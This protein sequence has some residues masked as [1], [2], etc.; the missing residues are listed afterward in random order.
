V[1]V[2]ADVKGLEVVTCAY[3]SQDHV[4]CDEVRSKKDFHAN[5]QQRFGFPTGDY[6]RVKAKRFM[7]KL[8]YGGSA[9]GYT[10]DG[11][12][13]DLEYSQERWQGIID[14]FYAKYRGV[15]E[16]HDGLVR[17]AISDGMFISPSGRRYSYPSS[18]VAARMWY[19]RPKI[20]NYPVQGLGADLVM[21]ARIT[22]WKRL[23]QVAERELILPVSSVHDSI[24]L[25]IPDRMV[26]N[27]S[28]VLRNSIVDVPRNFERCFGKPFNLPLDAEVKIGKN[29]KEMEKIDC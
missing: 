14:E 19:W 5:N 4:L 28:K 16:W 22:L 6:G 20:L 21:L 11:D 12:F 29:L 2:A 9:Y 17:T 10:V 3:L 26:Y 18:D 23:S 13:V 25:D 7:F 15:R 24:V 27:I 8:I 1:L